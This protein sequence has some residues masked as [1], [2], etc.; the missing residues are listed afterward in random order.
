MST[1]D[2]LRATHA[3]T[4][5]VYVCAD[6]DAWALVD[7]ETGVTLSTHETP[8]KALSAGMELDEVA[9]LTKRANLRE[10]G[11]PIGAWRWLDASAEE[12]EPIVIANDK[13]EP[14]GSRITASSLWEMAAS[15]NT[16]GSAVPINGG[17]APRPGLGDS[18]PHGDDMGGDHLANGYAHV[19]VPVTDRT[20]RVHLYLWSELLPEIAAE[21]DLGRLAYGSVRFGFDSADPN[22]GYAI[23]GAVLVSHALTNDPAVTS[24]TAG[25]ERRRTDEPTHVACRSRRTSMS[26]KN[27]AQRGPVRDALVK[28]A[29]IL[30]ISAE[31]LDDDPYSLTEAVYALKDAAKA[32]AVTEAIMGAE[33]PEPAEGE[34]AEE[35]RARSAIR[36]AHALAE[37]QR[38]VSQREVEGVEPEAV[39]PLLE[40]FIAF[41][42]T[43]LA[44]PDA[45]PG[46]VADE[47]E[48]RQ[49]EIA[50]ALGEDAPPADDSGAGEG[51]E[52]EA[53]RSRGR[54]EL[55]S[56]RSRVERI[57]SDLAA[58]RAKVSEYETGEWI[59]SEVSK[60]SLSL[61]KTE[62]SKLLG[63][64]MEKGRDV[65]E[66][67][68]DARSTPP[69]GNPLDGQRSRVSHDPQTI[70]EA[71]DECMAEVREKHPDEQPHVQRARAQKLARIRYPH[72]SGNDD[73]SA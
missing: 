33:M 30:G 11:E 54:S 39:E 49:D 24:L 25:S 29:G 52:G 6:G 55:V 58:E 67:I 16:R 27:A 2:D 59:D 43:V 9:A 61:P 23:K 46:E 41:A 73:G 53:E 68:L 63:V 14:V 1:F 12:D 17:G 28:I 7:T 13:G 21:V 4:V 51:G 26:I 37:R 18:L 66:M 38:P 44:K 69:T 56:L 45:A 8:R 36:A 47:L 72:L 5:P 32:E 31:T 60:R 64:A 42:R 65:V 40:R 34:P 22:D 57:E 35:A 48:A 50:D 70:A 19:G 71:A 15:L 20:G 10:D 62:R 3:A